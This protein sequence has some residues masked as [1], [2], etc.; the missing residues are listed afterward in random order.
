LEITMFSRSPAAAD[1]PTHVDV[2]SS[3]ELIPLSVL[4]LDLPAPG[5]GWAAHLAHR[6]VEIVLDDIGRAA[7]ARGDARRLFTEQREAEAANRERAAAM[8]R[9]AVEQ[10]RQWRAQLPGGVP[11][12]QIPDGV[13]PVVAMTQADRD[14]QPRRRSLLE[15][16]LSGSAMTF[17]PIVPDGDEDS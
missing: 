3:E 13:L 6:G 8:E 4:A 10:D 17:H 5:E 12:Y 15:E 2:V 9:A 7:V 1:P 11:W 16:S 14:A